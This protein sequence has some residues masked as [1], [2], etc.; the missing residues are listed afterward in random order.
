MSIALVS[1]K[2]NQELLKEKE[3]LQ[4]QVSQLTLDIKALN[5]E[6]SSL[7]KRLKV[8]EPTIEGEAK[9]PEKEVPEKESPQT[10]KLSPQQVKI[11]RIYRIATSLQKGGN[12]EKAAQAYTAILE[13]EPEYQDVQNRLQDVKQLI[14][15]ESKY[16]EGFNHQLNQRY[17]QAKT[18]YQE[19][20]KLNPG[21]QELKDKLAEVTTEIENKARRAKQL[22]AD[23]IRSRN[24]PS[25]VA[26]TLMDKSWPFK[27]DIRSGQ[28]ECGDNKALY[29]KAKGKVYALNEQAKKV[30]PEFSSTVEIRGLQK[31]MDSTLF[32]GN[33]NE[34]LQKGYSLCKG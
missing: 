12:Y 30:H 16:K 20:L 7:K 23:L 26:E 6:N 19:A 14:L 5:E 4:S 31:I 15:A 24:D 27:N 8:Y 2:D 9:E 28:I 11:R 32:E 29:F 22:Q 34:L 3:S 25:Y 10:P 33:L 21:N 13:N 1:C 18:M 17:S